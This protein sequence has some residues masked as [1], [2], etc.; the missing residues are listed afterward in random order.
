MLRT[1]FREERRQRSR[2]QIAE[3]GEAIAQHGAHLLSGAKCVAAYVNI[4]FEPPSLPLIDA[5]HDQGV[6]VMLPALGP[7]LARMWAK[8]EGMDDLEVRAPKRPPEPSGEAV[9]T[10][11]IRGVDAVIAPGLAVDISGNRLGQGGGWYD[12]VLKHLPDTTPVWAVVY[13][14]EFIPGALPH[15]EMDV[16]VTGVIRP[17]GIVRVDR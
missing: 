9:P 8:F 13:D 7:G 14:Q 3:A 5:L 12:R 2:K 17:S 6:T 10:S 4:D 11:E 15:G 1:V 16:P